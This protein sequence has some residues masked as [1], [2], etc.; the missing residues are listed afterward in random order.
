[1]VD[2]RECMQISRFSCPARVG[3][4]QCVTIR[5]SVVAEIFVE[6]TVTV[7]EYR[8]LLRDTWSQYEDET[9]VAEPKGIFRIN[10]GRAPASMVP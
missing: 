2:G 4:S 5:I 1:M 7:L 9:F 3:L 8:V 10:A 6:I